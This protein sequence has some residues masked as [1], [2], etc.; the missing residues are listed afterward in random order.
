MLTRNR[1]SVISKLA[2]PFL[3]ALSSTLL[4][5]LIDLAMVGT[6]GIVTV[7]AVGMATFCETLVAAS[8]AGLT[9]AVQGIVARRRGEG[10]AE[11]GCLPLN[12]GLLASVIVGVPLAA[13]CYASVPF[14]MSL[15]S[16]DPAVTAVA[17]P[18]LRILYLGLVAIGMNNAF[19]GYWAGVEKPKIYM[20]VIL[21]I[22]A[23]NIALN[24]ALIFGH[25]GLPALGARGAAIGTTAALYAGVLLNAAIAYL[26]L[27]KDGF[28]KALPKMPL[29]THIMKLGLPSTMQQFL[30]AAGYITFFWMVGRVGTAELAAASVLI[31]VTMVMVLLAMALGM[32]SATL[33]SRT[34]GE[35]DIEGANQWGWDV[36]KLGVITITA[37][38]LPLLLF[39]EFFLAFFLKDAHSLAIAVWPLRMVAITSG[40]GSLIYIFG[41]TLYSVGDGNRVVLVSF[42][43]QWVFFLP[44]VWL[45]GP[46]LHSGLLQIWL[47]QM[48]YGALATALITAIWIDGRWKR[49]QI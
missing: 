5:A 40:A 46:Y 24:Y 48:A 36:G 10:S 23:L 38:G 33:V 29:L 3:I 4:L 16:S 8:V 45:V 21:T 32:A 20:S 31:R 27:R 13:L 15:V 41:Y 9:P 6:L 1:V 18:F 44:L 39:P 42:S 30:F 35:A 43:T 37:L 2:F 11:P 19:E 17:I 14:F 34:V 26:N 49:I 25:F 12:A 47:V 7:A 28:L 22:S